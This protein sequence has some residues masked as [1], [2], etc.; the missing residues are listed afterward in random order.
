MAVLRERMGVTVE[1]AEAADI[2]VPYLR[3]WRATYGLTQIEL[4]ERAGVQRT[5]VIR[6]ESGKPI[7]AQTLGKLARALGISA[8]TLRATPPTAPAPPES[9]P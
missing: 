6:A 9:E 3:D 8:Y 2:T 1:M 7:N 5:T 4:A